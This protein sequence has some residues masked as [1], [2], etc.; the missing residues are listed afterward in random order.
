MFSDSAVN[1]KFSK[2][3]TV[4]QSPNFPIIC[5]NIPV[6]TSR[7]ISDFQISSLQPDVQLSSLI[8]NSISIKSQNAQLC[9]MRSIWHYWIVMRKNLAQQKM[10]YLICM[11]RRLVIYAFVAYL[12]KF[13]LFPV[14][15]QLKFFKMHITK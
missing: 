5:N 8:N 7:N 10:N 12:K 1:I 2:V 15:G 13:M 4:V 6:R 3:L 14:A 11:I 9:H